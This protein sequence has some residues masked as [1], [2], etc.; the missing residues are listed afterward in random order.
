MEDF[1]DLVAEVWSQTV[2]EKEIAD[3]H[4]SDLNFSPTKSFDSDLLN[5]N[6]HSCL[7]HTP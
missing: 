1:P 5:K 7:K 3:S 2:G 6:A 4:R